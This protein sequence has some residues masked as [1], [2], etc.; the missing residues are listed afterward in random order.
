MI[1]V[2]IRRAKDDRRR[3]GIDD[4]AWWRRTSWLSYDSDAEV[5]G[6]RLQFSRTGM[7]RRAAT[8]RDAATGEV[9][10]EWSARGGRLALGDRELRLRRTG[11][12]RRKWSI[13]EG[14]GE[15]ARFEPEGRGAMRVLVRPDVPVPRLLLLYGAWLVRCQTEDE[16]AAVAAGATTAAVSAAG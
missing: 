1:E 7:L 2:Q 11:R 6:M 13:V 16:D 8:A 14:A 10:A 3:Y 9:R 12:W 4:D 15:L 5:D